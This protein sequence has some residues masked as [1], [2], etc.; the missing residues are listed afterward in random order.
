MNVFKKLWGFVKEY[1]LYL[2]IGLM[3]IY[4]YVIISMV[5]GYIN[6]KVIDDVI[7][8]GKLNILTSLLIV[9][10]TANLLRAVFALIHRYFIENLSQSILKDLKQA[11]YDHLQKM[12]FNYYNNHKTGEL[13]SRMTGDMQA[14]RRMI[15]EGLIM[16]S[17]AVFYYISV[18]IVLFSINIKL[19][20]VS[21]AVTPLIAF[22]AYRLSQRIRP[23]FS[24]IRKQ[25]SDLNSIVQENISGIRIVKAF[26]QQCYEI[27]KFDDENNEYFLKNYKAARIWSSFFPIIEFLGGLSTVLLLYF[28][29]SMVISGEISIG[30][31]IQFNSYLWMLIMPMRMTGHVVNMINRTI[32]AG[33]RIF[34]ILETEPEIVSKKDTVKTDR[35]KG[36]VEF[37]N[38]SLQYGDQKVLKN[39]NLSVEAGSTVAIMGATGSGKTSLINLI[40]RYYEASE[41][42]LLIDSIDV[43]DYD[44]KNLRKQI[45]IVMQDV[46]LFSETIKKNIT[47]GKSD[48]EMKDIKN[49][50]EIAGASEFIE[51]MD[52]K[53]ETVVG[54]RGMGLS[55]GQK[56][57]VSI[58]R[59]I[60]EKPP[61]LILDDA[62]SAIDMETEHKIQKSLD[63]MDIKSTVFI[64]AHRISSVTKADMIIILEDGEI[65]EKGTHE[66]LLNN[67]GKYYNIFREQYKEILE[68]EGFNNK[69]VIS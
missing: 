62:T 38:I 31:W 11:L 64:I 36:K 55:G 21:L 14:I 32:A 26:H 25:Y 33:E 42:K 44:L 29:G 51:N 34:E 15:A 17:Q 54:E 24:K 13:M 37:K 18:S 23:V 10:I 43:K 41:G 9:F 65:I 60:V 57:R 53:Y 3:F 20:L 63:N 27:E 4:L 50:A 40:G 68:D 47:Y 39:I 59:A 5:P 67:K 19:T 2:F 56:Q 30:I 6:R 49:A 45:S 46:F 66:E 16:S 22:F 52:E 28:G 61:I 69:M 35:I 58:A 8:N 1:K 48:A 12:S 7:R